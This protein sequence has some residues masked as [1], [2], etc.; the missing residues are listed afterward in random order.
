[1]NLIEWVDEIL[2]REWDPI[3]VNDVPACANEY[4]SYVLEIAGLVACNAAPETIAAHLSWIEATKMSSRAD[5]ETVY[6]VALMLLAPKIF[7]RES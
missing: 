5:P 6:R 7:E 3:G 2:L 1:M 4:S